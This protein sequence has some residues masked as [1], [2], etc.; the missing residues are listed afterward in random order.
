M[1]DRQDSGTDRN[2]VQGESGGTGKGPRVVEVDADKFDEP[3]GYSHAVGSYWLTPVFTGI[4]FIVA[5]YVGSNKDSLP[6]EMVLVTV[7][8][9]ITI[10]STAYAIEKLVW[11]RCRQNRKEE[12]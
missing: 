4:A 7:I 12:R 9:F 6:Q 8:A 1:A 10:L 2:V 11:R 3:V 5:F